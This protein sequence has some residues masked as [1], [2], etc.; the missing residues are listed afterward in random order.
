VIDEEKGKLGLFFRGKKVCLIDN[1]NMMECLEVRL[2]SSRSGNVNRR[3]RM[4][5]MKVKRIIEI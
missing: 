4:N 5:D 2:K 1:S 3:L